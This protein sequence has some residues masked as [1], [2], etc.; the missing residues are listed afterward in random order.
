VAVACGKVVWTLVQEPAKRVGLKP[1]PLWLRPWAALG[2]YLLSVSLLAAHTRGVFLTMQ[3]AKPLTPPLSP[4]RGEREKILAQMNESL[5][6]EVIGN[7]G[8]GSLSPSDGERDRVRGRFYCMDTA[9]M[10]K[11][12]SRR[13]LCSIPTVNSG[14]GDSSPTTSCPRNRRAKNTNAYEILV[15]CGRIP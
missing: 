15:E 4:R 9:E 14:S 1:K 5:N 13:E 12:S 10:F 7:Q 11:L 2:H 3:T 6:G 8:N